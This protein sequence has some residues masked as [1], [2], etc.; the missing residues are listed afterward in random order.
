V[1]D[2]KHLSLHELQSL[3]KKGIADAHPLPYWVA[4][5]ISELKVNYSGH[6]YLELVE[7]GGDNA[8]PRAKAGAVIWR[9]RYGSIGSRFKTV[10]GGDLCAGIRVLVRVVIAYHELYGMSLQIVDIEPSY[11]LGDQE[12]RRRE[13]I[14]RLRREGVYDMNRE[15][16]L[17][18]VLQRL[19]VVSSSN[20]AGYQDFRNEIEANRSGY[21]YRITLFPAVMQGHQ[22]E[23]SVIA[24][25][26]GIAERMDD[27]DA[28]VVIRGGGSQ[29]DLAAFDS[30]RLAS[31][32]AQFPLPVL[33]G[34]GHDK[35]QS[36]ADL[37]A[38]TALKT[39][40][41]VAAF[42]TAHN[43]LFEAGLQEV[44]ARITGIVRE[45]LQRERLR[46][47]ASVH[48]LRSAASDRSRREERRLS[49]AVAGVRY[50]TTAA[51]Q[52]RHSQIER[53]AGVATHAPTLKLSGA[54][55]G[56][57]I[58]QSLLSDRQTGFLSNRRRELLLLETRL[59]GQNPERILRRGYAVVRGTD[60]RAIG[61]LDEVNV[62]DRLS[63]HLLDGAIEAEVLNKTTIEN[64][65]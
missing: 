5:E 4:A 50:R 9:D 47:A 48:A 63:V 55:N 52:S 8:V 7:K 17:P 2:L 12:A 57:K 34:I 23:A 46:V 11:T 53:L 62:G 64:H 56:L 60:G 20:A 27:F 19:A 42:L 15:I 26:D 16:E 3:I 41:A 31:H 51:L 58:L 44:L 43:E 39:P 22:T 21:A 59:E 29:S 38:H 6:C 32:L 10:T 18:A 45:S 37:V 24:A 28:V 40:T 35:D 36:V 33:T 61:R 30:Y 14:E 54:D 65:G 13:A 25:L 1:S 49:A